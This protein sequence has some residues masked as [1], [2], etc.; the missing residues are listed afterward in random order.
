[1]T[2]NESW[3][4]RRG[5]EE[6]RV[7]ELGSWDWEVGLGLGRRE[8]CVVRRGVRGREGL[9]LLSPNLMFKYLKIECLSVSSSR[10]E[11]LKGN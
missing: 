6:G 3:G 10:G 9:H 4:V 7:G 2:C 1:M 5:C 11:A 8:F